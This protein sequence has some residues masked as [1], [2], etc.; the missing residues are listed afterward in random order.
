M[1]DE[2][3]LQFKKCDVFTPDDISKQMCSYL[4]GKGSLLDPAVGTGNLIK[5]LNHKT[6]GEIDIYDIKQNYLDECPSNKNIHK[7]LADFIK[8]DI[9][10]KYDNI[11]LNPPY[12]RY[13]DLSPEYRTYIKK[14]WT[15]LVNGNIDMYYAFL[16]KCIE[17]LKDDGVMVAITPNSYIY[18]K[19]ASNLRKYF[20]EKRLINKIVDFQSKKVFKGISTYCC[21]TVFTKN[22][23]KQSFTYNGEEI[24]YSLIHNYNIFDYTTDNTKILGDICNI[25]NGIAT[26]RDK[27]YVHENKLFEEPCWK[28]ITNGTKNSWIIMPYDPD[29]KIIE[30]HDFAKSNPETHQYLINNKDELAKRDKGNKKYSKWYS[31]GRT[32]SITVPKADKVIYVPTFADPNNISYN[33]ME[34]TYHIS[35]LCIE[36]KSDEYTIEEIVQILKDHREFIEKNSSKRGGGWINISGSILKKIPV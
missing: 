32:Q 14:K 22:A 34:P 17:H 24:Q 12:I 1:I 10:K 2:Q 28:P 5:Y 13:Q 3:L 15:H 20:I 11:I 35:S 8:T 19:S 4:S 23:G 18:N 26:L 16:L 30:E 36:L 21:I 27:I 31:F 33:V 9:T 7:H 25:R 29:G 6:Y